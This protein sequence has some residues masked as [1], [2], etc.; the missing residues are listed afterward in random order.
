VSAAAQAGARAQV[1]AS[2]GESPQHCGK[3][4]NNGCGRDLRE[5]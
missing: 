4:I 5:S 1:L 3:T 2:A